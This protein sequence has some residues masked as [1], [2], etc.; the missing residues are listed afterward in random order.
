M[1]FLSKSQQDFFWKR[2][3]Y[4]KIFVVIHM[5]K[6]AKT[7][8]IKKNRVRRITLP[9]IKAYYITT[10]IRLWGI[11]WRTDTLI[12]GTEYK[13][14]KQTYTK[15]FNWFLENVIK[16]FCGAIPFQEMAAST[17]RNPEAIKM[18]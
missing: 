14:Q 3:G 5:P 13:T 15:M 6:I 10:L 18:N 4:F 1:Q 16:Q 17:I 9:N 11:S 12:N 7:I 8:L 2:Q